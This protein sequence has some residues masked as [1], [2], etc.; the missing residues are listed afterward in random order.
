MEEARTRT[1]AI[2]GEDADLVL[3]VQ[4]DRDSEE[5]DEHLYV[6]LRTG[7]PSA[8]ATKRLDKLDEDWWLDAVPQARGRMTI[9][10]E[11]A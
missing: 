9:A 10:L 6:M 1:R 11:F 4:A 2:F 5:P 7:L 8:E 3:E